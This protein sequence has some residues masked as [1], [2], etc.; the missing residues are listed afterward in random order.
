MSSLT[1]ILRAHNQ[2][3]RSLLNMSV[4]NI[5]LVHDQCL[6]CLINYFDAFPINFWKCPKYLIWGAI[7][8]KTDE[9]TYDVWG[10]NKSQITSKSNQESNMN[11]TSEFVYWFIK[12]E[13]VTYSSDA[14]R[15][16]LMAHTRKE[17]H[18][19]WSVKKSISLKW[20][21]SFSREEK[22]EA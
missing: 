13:W 7:S 8:S 14:I 5:R 2:F 22:N 16:N 10:I 17:I 21:N 6:R 1:N 20:L 3:H 11:Q 19:N 18:W 15:S 12:S 9:K 4:T